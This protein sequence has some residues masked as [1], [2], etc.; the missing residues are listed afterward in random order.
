MIWFQE[1][2]MGALIHPSPSNFPHNPQ[3]EK[4]KPMNT[5]KYQQNQLAPNSC[6]RC[7]S[8]NTKFCYYN[9][10]SLS[11][12]R[13]F[14]KA[15]R[16]YWTK[17]GILRNVPVGGGCRKN[18]IRSS[19]SSSSSDPNSSPFAKRSV[20][21]HRPQVEADL[22]I[23]KNINLTKLPPSES[24]MGGAGPVG[25][26]NFRLPSDELTLAFNPFLLDHQNP[27]PNPSF[28]DILRGGGVV[29]PAAQQSHHGGAGG[30]GFH[31]S[32][33]Y[34]F[35]GGVGGGNHDHRQR[36]VLSF[37]GGGGSGGGS[38]DS[39]CT[40]PL[41]AE[42]A[43]G[44]AVVRDDEDDDVGGNHDNAAAGL[45]LE[46]SGA[47]RDY[48]NDSASVSSSSSTWHGLVNGSFL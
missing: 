36:G 45:G 37:H 13:Y 35:G 39:S 3:Q 5:N 42:R 12:P 46:I 20:S 43:P 6:P 9:N 29:G 30:G 27:N 23:I 34:G 24:S 41:V 32:L 7:D 31:Q 8:T 11:Q 38:A 26:P 25:I 15:C 17:G 19:S 28:L 1:G 33:C 44:M 21:S 16:R 2:R 18:K 4:M 47:G 48:W 14:C 40:A 10:Y 22:L